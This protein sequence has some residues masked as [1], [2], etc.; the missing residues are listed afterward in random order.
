MNIVEARASVREPKKSATR[1]NPDAWLKP[2]VLLGSL[3]PLVF[4]IV[5]ALRGT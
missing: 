3:V 2:G 5:R 1:G 4:I